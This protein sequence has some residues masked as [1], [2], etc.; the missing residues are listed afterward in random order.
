MQTSN[1]IT[2]DNHH[3]PDLVRHC[4]IAHF[5]VTAGNEAGVDLV[6]IQLFFLYYVNHVVLMLASIFEAN[7]H[8][9]RKEVC[10]KTRSTSAL[11]SLK[12]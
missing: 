5:T 1:S 11:P 4:I 3:E 12:G 7:F 9:R 2:I 10:I 6:W 8:Y